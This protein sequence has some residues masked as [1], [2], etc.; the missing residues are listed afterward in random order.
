MKIFFVLCWLIFINRGVSYANDS[1]PILETENSV[2][3]PPGAKEAP[4]IHPLPDQAPLKHLFGVTMDT[5]LVSRYIWHGLDYSDQKPVMQP[6]IIFLLMKMSA[7]VWLNYDF[8]SYKA[9][10]EY[11]LTLQYADKLGPAGIS[12]GYSY[13]T[14]PN[15]GWS[16]SEEV[17]LQGS[18]ESV[19]NPTLGIHDDF[20]SENGWYYNLGISHDFDLPIGNLTP[21][22]LL[23][24]HAHCY[25]GTGFPASEFNLTD[26]VSI[27]QVTSKVKISYYRALKNGD[28][29]DLDDQLV[30]SLNLS[31][32]L[33]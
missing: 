32:S 25:G 22:A 16:D 14:Y 7:I 31:W 11:D 10:N 23:Y 3:T 5:T 21:A 15:R 2:L 27:G 6:E 17:W 29:R 18:Y 1:I 4:S 33:P 13:F 12:L 9:V 19:L 8:Q 30:Y 24:Y 20:R 26:A 28:F